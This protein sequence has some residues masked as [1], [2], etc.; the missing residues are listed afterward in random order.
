MKWLDRDLFDE[1][2]SL[3]DEESK[4]KEKANSSTKSPTKKSTKISVSPASN[5]TNGI[6]KN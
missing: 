6:A 1:G 4:S 5:N 2:D 3:R